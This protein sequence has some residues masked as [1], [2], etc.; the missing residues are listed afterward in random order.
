MKTKK[1]LLI[2]LYCIIL[3]I[4][5]F[6][7]GK[8]QYLQYLNEIEKNLIN[9][10]YASAITNAKLLLKYY[11]DSLKSYSTLGF[12]YLLA[13]SCKLSA[14]ICR[15]G[16]NLYPENYELLLTRGQAFSCTKDYVKALDD[17]N[18]AI[19]FKQ[20]PSL[21]LYRG[22][23]YYY[24]G[25]Y[26]SAI[27]DYTKFI[28]IG[29]DPGLGYSLRSDAKRKLGIEF[30]SDLSKALELGAPESFIKYMTYCVDSSKRE[31]DSLMPPNTI[32][33]Y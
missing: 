17:Y 29:N 27:Q 24:T 25:N 2:L 5:S 10:N 32:D 8:D 18:K 9:H 28:N 4:Y 1:Y 19:Q 7:Q 30:C 26:Q 33:D 21:Y 22:D 6:S 3:S 13:D 11:P 20:N 31:Y 23:A 14:T 16:L 12:L 15:N